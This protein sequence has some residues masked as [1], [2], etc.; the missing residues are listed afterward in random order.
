MNWFF[1]HL[2]KTRRLA[3]CLAT[4]LLVSAVMQPH[5]VCAE[6]DVLSGSPVVRKNLMYRAARHEIN[7]MIGM[8]LADPYVR[9]VLPGVRYDYHLFDWLSVGGRLQVGIPVVT[10][11]Y[12]EID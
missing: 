9:N 12:N 8:T 10:N 5:R 4:M 3:L 2:L 6:E 7:G 11:L 1:S